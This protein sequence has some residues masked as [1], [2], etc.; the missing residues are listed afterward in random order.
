MD[1]EH[2][3]LQRRNFSYYMRVKEEASGKVIGH[4]SDISMGGFRIDC[5]QNIPLNVDIRLY[6][7]Q[8]GEISRKTYILIKARPMWCQQ[9]QFDPNMY[10]VGFKIVDITPVDREIYL[11]M[12]ETYG[13]QHTSQL[14]GFE[15]PTE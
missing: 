3:S 10:N 9:D 11:K 6:I 4:I 1:E 13:A 8:I 7:D 14:D 5:T 2:R 15:L 12:Y